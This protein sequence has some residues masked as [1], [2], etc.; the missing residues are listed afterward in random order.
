MNKARKGRAP[1]RG[2][3]LSRFF[4]SAIGEIS[5]CPCSA[6][7]RCSC[8]PL[9]RNA[10]Q[11]KE[12]AHQSILYSFIAFPIS[13]DGMNHTEAMEAF[14]APGISEESESPIMMRDGFGSPIRSGQRSKNSAAGFVTPVSSLINK[15]SIYQSGEPLPASGLN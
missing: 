15:P 12:A 10:E 8:R 7:A 4:M 1:G 2:I 13:P 14:F 6:V 5:Q 11:P 9:F 3:C